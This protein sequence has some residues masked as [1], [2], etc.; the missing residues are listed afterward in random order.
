MVKSISDVFKHSKSQCVFIPFI[1]AGFPNIESTAKAIKILDEEG[2]DIIELGIPYSDPLADG[3]VIQVASTQA[4]LNGTRFK[5]ISDM[6]SKLIPELR[7]P[8]VLFSYYNPI[9]SMGPKTFVQD[10]AKLGVQGLLIP[11]LPLEESKELL[12]LTS[13][14]GVDLIMLIAPTSSL[15]RI[16][17]IANLSSGCIYLVSSTGVTGSR[18]EFA[19]N[20]YSVIE[21]IKRVTSNPIIV[22]FGI[23]HAEHIKEIKKLDIQGVVMGSALV[24]SLATD[25]TPG[26]DNFRTLCRSSIKAI[27]S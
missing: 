25:N 22:G 21:N 1:T 15:S 2:A 27:G 10:I 14:Y 19:P 18:S 26:L 24:N 7:A 17:S 3:P 13:N 9:L 6:L 16:R 20:I 23:S 5:Q 11:D 12:E 4:L 8:I